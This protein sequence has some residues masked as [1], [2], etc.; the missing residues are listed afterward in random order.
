MHG[1]GAD[2]PLT[3]RSWLCERGS[4]SSHKCP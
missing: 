4:S 3:V 2:A 1:Q